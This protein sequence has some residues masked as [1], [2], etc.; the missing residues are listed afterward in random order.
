MTLSSA[1]TVF[2]TLVS[3]VGRGLDSSRDRAAAQ[4]RRR[5]RRRARREYRQL[6]SANDKL[7]RDVGVSRADVEVAFA[8]CGR[9]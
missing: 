8:E 7:L 2:A 1:L 6:L 3:T 4:A 5:A 9:R